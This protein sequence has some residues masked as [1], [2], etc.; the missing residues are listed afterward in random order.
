MFCHLKEIKKCLLGRGQALVAIAIVKN[1][2]RNKK[3]G[4]AE[5]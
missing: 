4:I 1:Y 2:L 3:H 5:E